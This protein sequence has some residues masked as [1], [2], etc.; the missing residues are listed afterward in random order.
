MLFEKESL[1]REGIDDMACCLGLMSQGLLIQNLMSQGLLIRNGEALSS[2]HHLMIW[3]G[4]WDL[5]ALKSQ[6]LI[7]ARLG[8]R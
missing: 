2:S 8:L 1:I 4:D 5:L 3:L 7:R 6:G